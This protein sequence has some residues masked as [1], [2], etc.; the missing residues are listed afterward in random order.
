[1]EDLIKSLQKSVYSS[2][3]VFDVKI[4]E[5]NDYKLNVQVHGATIGLYQMIE[6]LKNHNYRVDDIRIIS[7]SENLFYVEMNFKNEQMV[8]E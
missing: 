7:K 2:F 5:E 3:C 1:M 4:Y 8:T 6:I